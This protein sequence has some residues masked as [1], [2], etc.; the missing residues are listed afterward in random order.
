MLPFRNR[1]LFVCCFLFFLLFRPFSPSSI[2]TIFHNDVYVILQF[3][4]ILVVLNFVSVSKKP[5]FFRTVI[6]RDITITIHFVIWT[7]VR[8]HYNP[9]WFIRRRFKVHGRM[10]G[11]QFNT[12]KRLG[13]RMSPCQYIDHPLYCAAWSSLSLFISSYI[14]LLYV[15]QVGNFISFSFIGAFFVRN[16]IAVIGNF[17]HVCRKSQT[18]SITFPYDVFSWSHSCSSFIS[19]SDPSVWL[20]QT[21]FRT[22]PCGIA[23]L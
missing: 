1:K 11:S 23:T 22:Y 5:L 10:H 4:F 8:S 21:L 6:F 3:L 16:N 9:S 7:Y 17:F 15:L 18:W 12:C 19:N 14:V 2:H 20:Y 13:H